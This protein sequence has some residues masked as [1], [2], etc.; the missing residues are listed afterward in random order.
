LVIAGPAP[1]RLNKGGLKGMAKRLLRVDA[2]QQAV[3]RAIEALDP[4][5]RSTLI[6]TGIRTDVPDMLAA[7]Q[8]L[9]FP[10]SVPHFARPVIE[11]AAMAVPAVASDLGGPRELIEDGETGRLV[12]PGN[13][14]ALAAAIG[15]LLGDPESARRMG[16]TA[17]RQARERF[18]ANRN[19]AATIALYDEIL[20][21]A[22]LS[23]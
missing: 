13:P 6:F 17:Y 11:A 2:Y 15:M 5:V 23:G 9:V 12:P 16:E 20:G 19:G 1:R 14:A 7:S 18:D 22:S 21:E 10:S 8:C 4:V 3:Q